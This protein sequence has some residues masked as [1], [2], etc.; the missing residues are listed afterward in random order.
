VQR[1]ARTYVIGAALAMALTGLTA[2]SGSSGGDSGDDTK[3]GE[4]TATADPAPGKYQTLPE[5]CGT[6]GTG[7]LKDLLPGSPGSPG[8]GGD[9]GDGGGS[10]GNASASPYQGQPSVTYDTDR[11]VG[12]HWKSATS[13]S[14]RHLSID[15]ERVVSYDPSV[16][17]DKQAEQLYTER[18]DQADIPGV[19]KPSPG[20]GQSGAPNSEKS[21]SGHSGGQHKHK[22]EPT[23][24][25]SEKQPQQGGERLRSDGGRVADG[26]DRSG[27]SAGHGGNSRT[28]AGGSAASEA[29]SGSASDDG[30][31]SATPSPD[32]DLSPRTL[33]DIGDNAYINDKL[34]TGDSGV[35]RDITLVFRSANVVATV[36]YDQ[37]L[38]DKDRTPDSADLQDKARKVAEELA[39]DLDS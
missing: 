11:R 7:T 35:H 19:A 36:K 28:R 29:G 34:D 33:D 13:L 10:A 25:R 2:C 12:C 38:T 15:L 5:P 30:S 3:S 18:A 32:D 4:S 27:G 14:T 22:G 39:S 6:I 21:D 24:K 37:W 16:S 8:S 31:P 1:T 20:E 17:D 23:R 9:G 26:A